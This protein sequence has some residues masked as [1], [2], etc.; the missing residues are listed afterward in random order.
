[1][2]NLKNFIKRSISFL[3]IRGAVKRMLIILAYCCEYLDRSIDLAGGGLYP[4]TAYTTIEEL[5]S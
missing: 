1:M 5:I 4:S 2:V 3:R